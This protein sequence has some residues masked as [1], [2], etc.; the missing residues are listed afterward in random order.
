MPPKSE[1][2]RRGGYKCRTPEMHL[3]LRD[4]QLKTL[5]N[6]YRLLYQNFRIT[7]NQKS[8]IDTQIRKINSNTTLKIV[9]KPQED[10]TR[11][12]KKKEQQKKSKAIN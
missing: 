10:R 12:G 7:A 4:Q 5:P 1:I 6:I 9:I 11:E 3:Q 8:T 2:M